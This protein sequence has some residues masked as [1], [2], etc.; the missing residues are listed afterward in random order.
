MTKIINATMSPAEWALLVFLSV[1]WGGSFYFAG[2]ALKELPPVTIVVLRV[3]L[4]ALVLLAILRATGAPLPT[5]R[6]SWIALCA[7][8]FLNNALPFCLLMWAM[9]HIP[10][11]LG[12]ILNATT[13]LWTV[14]VAHASTPDERMTPRRLAGVVVGMIGVIAMI[15]PDALAG[16]G[17]NLVAQL[18]A[19]G[20]ALSYAFAGVYGRRFKRMGLAPMQTATGQ[21]VASSLMLLPIAVMVD[22]PWD[23]GMPSAAA[24]SAI[25]AAALLSTALGYIIY[26]RLLA[27]A[28]ATNLLLVTFLIPISAILL[29][30]ILLGERLEAK[31][32]LGMALIGTGLLAIDGRLITRMRGGLAPVP[33]T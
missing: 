23:L 25:V 17:T 3:A 26:F 5:D 24:V 11:G 10:S 4:A 9:T 20:A 30:T 16:V 14:M 19:L 29:G 1:L 13:P 12:S 15:G 32:F 18:A 6:K 21:V 31:H 8:G 27:T 2:V 33:R 7:M 22:R 28:G